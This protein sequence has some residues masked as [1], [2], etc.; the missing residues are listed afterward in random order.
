MLG[1]SCRDLHQTSWR[2][3]TVA[4]VGGGGV[5][6]DVWVCVSTVPRDGGNFP[7]CSSAGPVRY[8]L[9]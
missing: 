8:A 5:C 3:P 4:S 2:I 7:L 6:V 9:K 1:V